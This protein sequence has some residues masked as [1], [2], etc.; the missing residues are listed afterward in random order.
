MQKQILD[1]DFF[2]KF[3]IKEE[4]K[5][6]S[7]APLEEKEAL[8]KPSKEERT[9]FDDKD[10]HRKTYFRALENAVK[11]GSMSRSKA[12]QLRKEYDK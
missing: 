11:N 8:A 6:L 4:K 2:D 10:R 9:R 12:Y 5:A 7:T 3:D 1:P